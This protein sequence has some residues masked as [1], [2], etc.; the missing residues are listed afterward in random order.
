MSRTGKHS[1]TRHDLRET[2][3]KIATNQILHN[4]KKLERKPE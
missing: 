2:Q 1:P 4:A 3:F